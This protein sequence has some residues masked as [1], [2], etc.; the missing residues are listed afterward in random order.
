MPDPRHIIDTG[1][2]V[3][4]LNRRDLH[5]AWAKATLGALSAPPVTC[6]AVLTEVCWHL[7]ESPE[8]VARVLEMA[9][10][11]ELLLYPVAGDEGIALAAL[12]RKYGRTIDL[13]DA[14][15]VRLSEILPRA[16]VIT[17]DAEHFAIYRRNRTQAIPVICP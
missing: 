15:L 2:I 1:P 17:T 5:H 9:P 11:G 16:K 8:A 6:E 13:A 14:G 7:R 10:R 12:V 3:A 4:L